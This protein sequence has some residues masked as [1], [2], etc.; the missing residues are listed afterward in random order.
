LERHEER[1][2]RASI[3]GVARNVL[4]FWEGRISSRNEI[5]AVIDDVTQSFFRVANFAPEGISPGDRFEMSIA[6]TGMVVE[7][8]S[9]IPDSVDDAF[10]PR[11]MGERLWFSIVGD[12]I[13]FFDQGTSG[14][15]V[16]IVDEVTDVIVVPTRAL[17]RAGER[18]FVF[19]MEDGVRRLRYIETGVR[20]SHYVEVLDGLREGELVVV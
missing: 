1:L 17:G 12:D 7:V 4:F 2:V 15:I 18:D 16:Y 13:L 5:V 19:V 6:Q 8:E 9:V 10:N 14:R 3:N 20:G 11:T